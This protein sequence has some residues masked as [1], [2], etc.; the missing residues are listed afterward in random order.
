MKKLELER[1]KA[2]IE[3]ILFGAG[4]KV[5]VKEIESVLEIDEKDIIS[6]IEQMKADYEREERGIQLIKID[7]A[8][9]LCSNKD[10][11]E[12]IYPIIDKR[13]KPNLSRSST[14]NFSNYSI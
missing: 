13:V 8:Y 12:Y 2:I 4:R 1:T 10:Y 11:Y 6:I 7:T 5:E 14:R 3:A 9:Q